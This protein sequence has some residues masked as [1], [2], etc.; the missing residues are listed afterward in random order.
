MDSSCAHGR[1]KS[2]LELYKFMSKI[3]KENY[4]N[5]LYML[6]NNMGMKTLVR[7]TWKPQRYLQG[8]KNLEVT[9]S[10]PTSASPWSCLLSHP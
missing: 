5:N 4:W 10:P 6:I 8:G 1:F 7:K 9:S 2:K 3:H